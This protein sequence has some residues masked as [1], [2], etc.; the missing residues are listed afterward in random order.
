M[1]MK[2]RDLLI[3]IGTEEL[4]P[5]AL[6]SLAK[7]FDD[8]LHSIISDRLDLH[9]PGTT[10]THYYYS[11][12]RLAVIYKNLRIKQPDRQVE[13]FGPAVAVAFDADGKPAKAAEGFARSSG[14]TVDQLEQKDGKLF[15]AALQSGRTAAELIPAAII[16]ALAK[17][18][19]PK[20]MRWG[21]GT[22]EFVRPVHWAVVLFGDAVIDCEILGVQAGRITY[23]HRYHHPGP[24]KLKS[25]RDYV[26]TLRAAKVW[27]ND[28]THELQGEIS[29][30]ARKL[31][32]EMGG[33]PLNNDIESALVAEI[34]ALVEWPVGIRGKFDPKFLTLPEEILIATLED[35]QR[36][37]PIREKMTGKLLPHFITIANIESND[38]DQVR[39]GNERVIVP[40][41]TDAMFFWDMDRAV[42][43]ESRIPALDGI[44]F[45]NKL[46]SIGDKIRRVSK[47]V[48]PISI[49]IGGDPKLA[50]RAAQLAKCDLVTNLAGEFPELQGIIGCYLAQ[51]DG[52]PD[53]VAKAIEEH[54]RPRFAGDR[55]PGTRAGQ[56]L[57]IAD[58]LD[59]LI[60]IF[61]IG[62]FPTGEKDPF[63]LRRAAIGLLRILCE[64][65]L[66]LDLDELLKIAHNNFPSEMLLSSHEDNM[67]NYHKAGYFV[68]E[69][70]KN[71]LRDQDY[72]ILEIEAMLN[73]NKRPKPAEYIDRLKAVRS[74]L[75]LPEAP[76]LAEADKRIRNILSKS[77]ITGIVE[78]TEESSLQEEAE[79]ILLRTTRLL[80]EQV[81]SLV[82]SGKFQD[83]L[84]IT[85]QI[86]QPVTQFF[87]KVMVNVDNMELRN[88]RFKLLEEVSDLTNRVA[89]ISKLAA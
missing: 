13:R 84:L 80:R 28:A 9:E 14:T 63:G 33:D 4:P 42:T 85:A 81:D 56:A 21:S 35:Q 58:K 60:G 3:E 25:P 8:R 47:L 22:A 15:Y 76:G 64:N 73:L 83:A 62:L 26:N 46:G 39:H 2:T 75:K 11:P 1:S 29:L 52:E 16:E 12:R 50:A 87:E 34:A 40:R 27:L 72:S 68:E 66:P 32:D 67:S 5:K 36:Y 59:T 49:S 82:Q 51:H 7:T 78:R 70:A 65:R 43:L 74:F 18:P 17:L 61:G 88:N 77:G 30:Q 45:Q 31:A 41:L 24:I 53:E 6:A 20:R 54:Y 48:E 69:R 19:I 79:K 10:K 55:L 86:H 89:N 23:G 38:I 37:F 71:Y 44:I 57:A